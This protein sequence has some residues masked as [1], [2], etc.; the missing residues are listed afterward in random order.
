MASAL[1]NGST[2]VWRVIRQRILIR[3]GYTCQLCGAEGADSVDHIVP[4][5]LGGTDHDDN[6]QTLCRRCNSSKGGRFFS[7]EGHHPT[8]PGSLSPRNESKSHEPAGQDLDSASY[9]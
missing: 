7:G 5:R 6:L 9:G 3:D 4:R 1:R 2:R 8:P